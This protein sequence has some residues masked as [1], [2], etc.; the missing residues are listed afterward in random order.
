MC[1]KYD[2]AIVMVSQL[3]IQYKKSC[4]ATALHPWCCSSF[5]FRFA[6]HCSMLVESVICFR[7]QNAF[8]GDDDGFSATRL[9]CRQSRWQS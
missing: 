9:F 6:I 1:S 3:K 5:F 4:G 8:A 2:S 7:C